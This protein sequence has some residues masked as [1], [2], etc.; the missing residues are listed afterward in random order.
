[1]KI[2]SKAEGRVVRLDS[3]K[4]S[5]LAFQWASSHGKD[6]RMVEVVLRE[7]ARIVRMDRGV[8]IT[9]TRHGF[10]CANSGVDAS[11][12]DEG[13]VTLL[14]EDPD[15]S[16]DRL[17]ISLQS[18]LGVRVGIIISDTFG[19]PWRDGLV[20]VALGVA[21][22]APMADLRGT[23]DWLGQTLRVTTV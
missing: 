1:Q 20:N 11:N 17:R 4:P 19:R 16:A 7:S 2:V 5:A 10:I 6:P 23:R 8:L 22:I 3:V 12:V 21:G 18:L 9:E 13:T 14:P 15:L